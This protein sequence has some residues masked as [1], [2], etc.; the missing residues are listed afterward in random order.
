MNGFADLFVCGRQDPKTYRRH[1]TH[2]GQI[3]DENRR[4]VV[5]RASNRC[6]KSRCGTQIDFTADAYYSDPF[7][8]SK[9]RGDRIRS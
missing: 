3:N 7:A 8:V 4:I 6:F 5:K 1:K 9:G 2:F